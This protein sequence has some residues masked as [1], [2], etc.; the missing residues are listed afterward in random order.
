MNSPH[1]N[2]SFYSGGAPLE[3]AKATML[4]LHG[5]GVTAGDILSLASEFDQTDFFFLAPQAAGYTWYPYTFLAPLQQNEPWLSSALETVAGGVEYLRAAGFPAGRTILLG[6]SQGACLA[7]E[8]AARN[9]CRY[10]GI[11]GLSGGLIGPPGMARDYQG[12]FDGTP[13]FLGCSNVDP[14]IPQERVLESEEVLRRQGGDVT[15][16]IYPGLGHTVNQDEL[17]YVRTMMEQSIKLIRN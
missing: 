10:G 16:R 17:D 9:A 1:Q 5:R 8:Y 2:A 14:H 13:I 12:T 3:Q 11:V 4:M 7:L 6:F 15:T